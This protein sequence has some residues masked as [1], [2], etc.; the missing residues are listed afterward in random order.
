M[1]DDVFVLRARVSSPVVVSPLVSGGVFQAVSIVLTPDGPAQF[2]LARLAAGARGLNLRDGPSVKARAVGQLTE[3][4]TPALVLE[5]RE[6]GE[7]V[8]VRVGV[9]QWA[10]ACFEGQQL[11]EIE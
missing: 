1:S 2:G 4:D 10:A 11:L 3:K 5:R 8:W 6:V 9:R 7:D